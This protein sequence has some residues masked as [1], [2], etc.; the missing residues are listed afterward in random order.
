MAAGVLAGRARRDGVWAHERAGGAGDRHIAGDALSVGDT[1]AGQAGAKGPGCRVGGHFL[2]GQAEGK[3]HGL[4]RRWQVSDAAAHDGVRLRAGL[5][6]KR[7]LSS[8]LWADS[9]Y[10]SRANERYLEKNGFTSRIH[11]K[12]L[13]GKPMPER[14]A[15][16]NAKKSPVQA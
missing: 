3:R 13:A 5:L 10:R 8:S 15:R 12:K 14:T 16:A 4:I 9:A 11:R 1:C 2:K 6:D 7:S